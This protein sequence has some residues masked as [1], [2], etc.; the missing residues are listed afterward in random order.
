VLRR[1]RST[2]PAIPKPLIIIDQLAGS[3]TLAM[4]DWVKVAVTSAW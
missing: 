1:C 4:T 3:G 2:A